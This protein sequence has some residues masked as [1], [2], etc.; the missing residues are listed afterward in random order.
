MTALDEAGAY[1]LSG[2][3]AGAGDVTHAA[4]AAPGRTL[5]LM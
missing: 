4:M 1:S 2:A 3:G 5:P